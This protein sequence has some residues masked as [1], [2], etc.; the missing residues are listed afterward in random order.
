MKSINVPKVEESTN[1][2]IDIATELAFGCLITSSRSQQ[3]EVL[4]VMGLMY[5]PKQETTRQ[6]QEA[7]RVVLA[8]LGV[9]W[10]KET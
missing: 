9:P 7:C 8:E 10:E 1:G 4:P 5:M 6:F 3:L 2:K